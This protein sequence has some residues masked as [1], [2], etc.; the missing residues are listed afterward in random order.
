MSTKYYAVKKEP[1]L[2]NR[3]IYLGH[4]SAGWLFL[5]REHDEIHTFPQFVKWLEDNVD[6]GEYVLFDEYNRQITKEEL[7]EKIE[8]AQNDTRCKNNP[9]NFSYGFKNVDGYRFSCD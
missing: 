8:R 3:E 1:C 6:T 5:F 4:S 2:Y 7:L 9:Y